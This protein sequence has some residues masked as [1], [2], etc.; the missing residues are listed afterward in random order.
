[1]VPDHPACY[2][3]K[4]PA[5]AL[6]LDLLYKIMRWQQ[7]WITKES[8]YFVIDSVWELSDMPLY[9]KN[10]TF[11]QLDCAHVHQVSSKH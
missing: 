4:L 6:M 9:F 5:V 8:I 2:S 11:G 10:A 1:M 3:N 7:W